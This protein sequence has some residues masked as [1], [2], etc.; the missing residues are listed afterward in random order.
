MMRLPVK[1]IILLIFFFLFLGESSFSQLSAYK[2]DRMPFSSSLYSDIAPVI[3]KDGILFCSD[4]RLNSFSNQTTFQ[5]DRL[6]NLFFVEKKDS[7]AWGRPEEI[8]S[9]G[10]GILYYGPVCIAP[11]GKTI[12]FT[13]SLISGKSAR[14]KGISNPRGIFIGE[15][16]GKD[17]INIRPFAFNNP[18]YSV[19]HPFISR[20]GKY[21]FF[22]SDMPGG[23]G[24]SDIYFCEDINGTWSDPVNLGS[25]VNSPSKENYPFMHSSGRLYF[26]SDRPGDADYL[27]GMD[28]YYTK[29]NLGQWDMAIPMPSPINSKSDDFAFITGND[30]ST[31][32][33]SRRTGRNDDIMSY[34]SNIIRKSDC[35]SLQKNSY[36]YEFIE[37]NAIKFDTMP[38]PF[39][40]RWDYGDGTSAEGVRTVHCYAGPGDYLV[41]LDVVN[42]LTDEIVTNEKTYDLVITPVE[43]PYISGP[44]SCSPGQEIKFSADSTY[45]PGWTI[46]Q[47]YW[48]F[49]D[50]TI[51]IGRN[52]VKTYPRPGIYNIQL[53]VTGSPGAGG[54]SRE[55]CVWKDITVGRQP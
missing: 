8:T 42:L 22:A 34:K 9:P 13:S 40:Y 1:N 23:Q 18:S 26:T 29:L 50:E 31:G 10:T 55:A 51:N 48:N 16:S 14:E 24:E 15:L 39:K 12:Y 47:F 17:I 5:D 6:Y 25:N 7:V 30:L 28:I 41:R 33:F 46:S 38:V 4:R 19:A 45:L 11:D 32:Y 2:I 49:G 37:E 35:D 54:A 27:G 52:V 53:I 43:Q 44:D 20:D 36:C 3:F 21:L